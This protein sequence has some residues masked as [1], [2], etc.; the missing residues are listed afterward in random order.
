MSIRALTEDAILE[1]L[2]SHR[3][4]RALAKKYG[5]HLYTVQKVRNGQTY[6]DVHAEIPR[7][8]LAAPGQSGLTCET[9]VHH[10][11]DGH[12]TLGLPE[13]RN[14]HFARLCSAY[15]DGITS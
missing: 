6:L 2:T 1:V 9:C 11:R 7:P 8:G 13:G 4:L 12:C 10:H 14:A 15:N 3:P 5:T